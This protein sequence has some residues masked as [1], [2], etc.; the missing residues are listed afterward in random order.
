[1]SQASPEPIQSYAIIR[2][3]Y[4]NNEPT[5]LENL[6]QI[7]QWWTNLH[8]KSVKINCIIG[9]EQERSTGGWKLI[10][11]DTI[12]IPEIQNPQITDDVLTFN[13]SSKIS[14]IEKIDY[15]DFYP[16]L[17]QLVVNLTLIKITQQNP[18]I[19]PPVEFVP[20]KQYVFTLQ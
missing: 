2:W 14:R 6:S 18:D 20:D 5:N 1:M 8:G 9:R 17:N 19:Q 13:G 15:L 11:E 16:N 10:E 3:I 12:E 7:T 4:G